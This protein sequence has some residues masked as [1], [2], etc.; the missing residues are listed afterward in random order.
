VWFLDLVMARHSASICVA[1]LT[2]DVSANK[3]R[4]VE[5]MCRLEAIPS[6]KLGSKKNYL[7]VEDGGVLVGPL[8]EHRPQT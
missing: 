5:T 8:L 7:E 3:D 4:G 6:V 1:T 2:F